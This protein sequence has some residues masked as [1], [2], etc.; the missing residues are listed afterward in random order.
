MSYAEVYDNGGPYGNYSSYCNASYTF[1]TVNP[2]GH[3]RVEVQSSLTHPAGNARLSIYNGSTVSGNPMCSYPTGSGGVYYS[4]GNSVTISFTADDDDPTQGFKVILC[5]YDNAIASQLLT[6]YVD[7]TTL[8][9]QWNGG[10]GSTVWY[11][12]WAIVCN[13]VNLDAFFSNPSNYNSATLN[14]PS[15]DVHD[16]PVGCWVVY[17]IYSLPLS[18]CSPVVMGSSSA[19]EE[20]FQC[21]CIK[22]SG[23]TVTPLQDSLL[24]SWT[25][26]SV[27]Q[28]WHI[29]TI[30]S[31]FDTVLPG[32]ASEITIPYDYS[33]Y[34]DYLSILSN[35]DF[36]CNDL[37]FAL[38]LGG[39]RQT[40]GQLRRG[41]IT[42]SSI[43]II[44]NDALD[45]TTRYLLTISRHFPG[46][47]LQLFQDT[48]PFG[49]TSYTFSG[50]SPLT[51]YH[52]EISTICSDGSLGC[53]ASSVS[54]TTLLDNCID[55][56][57][58]YGD[59]S[60]IYTYGTYSNPTS[61]GGR[62]YGRHTVMTDTTQF[63]LNT[64]GALRCVPPG[65]LASFRL[66]DPDVGAKG[67]TVTY[68]YLVDSLDKDM[69]VLK[70]AVV[71]Q[72]SNHNSTNQPRFTMEILDNLGHLIDSACCYADFIAAGDLGWNNV[73]GSNIIWKDWTTVGI[74]IAPYHGQYIRIRFTTKDCADGGHFGYAYFVVHCDSKRIALVNLCE[75]DDSVRLRA[76]LGFHYRWSRD[77]DTTVI[78]T[79]NEIIVPA[80]S[81]LYH[82]YATFI[83]R[84]ECSFVVS[85]RA[86]LPYPKAHFDYYADTCGQRIAF[87]N[88][89]YVHIDSAYRKYV[90][91]QIDSI[92]WLIN[93]NP[94][95][96]DSIVL[97]IASDTL[98]RVHLL[99]RLSQ[100]H[101]FDTL[102][103]NVSANFS[104]SHHILADS[105]ACVGD[106]VRLLALVAPPGQSSFLWDNNSADTA[107]YALVNSDTTFSIVA[108]YHS[109]TDTVRHRIAVF[110]TNNDTIIARTCI[111]WHD[112]LGFNADSSGIYTLQLLNRH[113][114]DSLSTLDLTLFPS[115]YDTLQVLTCNQ[116]FVNDQFSEDSSGFYTH[117]YTTAH[118]CDSIYCLNLIR[119]QPFYDSATAEILYGDTYT[120]FGQSLESTGIYRQVLTDVHGC[121]STYALNLNVVYLSYP[122]VV[123]PN[124][125]GYNDIF[126][127]KGLIGSTIFDT[128]R[129]YIYDRWGRLI[130]S[131]DN[132]KTMDDFWDPNKT[133]TPDGTYYYLFV[134]ST[135][136]RQLIHKSVLEVIR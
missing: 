26:D 15:F 124:G 70:Y 135:P 65:E 38:P 103:R 69:L 94:Y 13:E 63:D 39:C 89:S 41:V 93:G 105:M 22:P 23:Y 10:S 55:Y 1:H 100:S 84:P 52:F 112:T 82:C 4:S 12:N 18:A 9:M 111:A 73:A 126:A 34:G 24:I 57:D 54:L 59:A 2:S 32:T 107:R 7:S 48:L 56:V 85:S 99:C 51:Q 35:C 127:I 128:P 116:P 17:N 5:E 8:H 119:H 91:Q 68:R 118:G 61:S 113:G 40:V 6:N 110:N 53:Y 81:S 43:E 46:Q 49:T 14:A 58:N 123:T 108:T 134:V 27:P 75:S 64:G 122:N 88:R 120:F 25:T 78:S 77:N 60:A 79:D 80:D 11:I 74:N 16:I 45:S 115:Y 102:S 47:S 3:Y 62:T 95:S 42:P 98:F 125:D 114:C 86:I 83:G 31:A 96:G 92:A 129:L 30:Y 132:I 104:H 37:Q 106:T 109:C 130:Y 36:V 117:A 133:D 50:L 19:Y 44:W 21:P 101:C 66:G 71:M 97:P 72:N 136:T 67:E 28:S 29:W 76:P 20:P 90:R 121:D 33:C 87:V 131:C